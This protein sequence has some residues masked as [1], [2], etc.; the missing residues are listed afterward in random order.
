MTLGLF[1]GIPILEIALNAG[2]TKKKMAVAARLQV[3]CKA[4]KKI[5]DNNTEFGLPLLFSCRRINMISTYAQALITQMPWWNVYCAWRDEPQ[6][7]VLFDYSLSMDENMATGKPTHL[8][9]AVERL[10]DLHTQQQDRLRHRLIVYVFGKTFLKYSITIQEDFEVL[11]SNIR[12]KQIPVERNK[13]CLQE[14]F[15]HFMT[16]KNRKESRWEIDLISDQKLVEEDIKASIQAMDTASD[17]VKNIRLK[18]MPTN[19]AAGRRRSILAA[20]EEWSAL[21]RK[22]RIEM[23]LIDPQESKRQKLEPLVVEEEL[24][25]FNSPASPPLYDY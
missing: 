5:V 8:S 22:D 17:T 20:Q 9:I 24:P 16:S 21:K 4:F 23:E 11:T 19:I 15:Q 12:T 18:F 10:Q 1:T 7:I 14:L 3:T 6:P 25:V 13:T 2:S